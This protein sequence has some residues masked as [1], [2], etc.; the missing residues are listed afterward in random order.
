M[1]W[2]W[3][4]GYLKHL[5]LLSQNGL[6]TNL[7][8]IGGCFTSSSNNLTTTGIYLLGPIKSTNKCV[9][10]Y[11]FQAFKNVIYVKTHPVVY[12][13]ELTMTAAGNTLLGVYEYCNKEVPVLYLVFGQ[14]FIYAINS[15][16]LAKFIAKI[17]EKEGWRSLFRWSLGLLQVGR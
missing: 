10:T 12:T 2:G 9:S 13:C 17:I 11:F 6:I 8:C 5:F 4:S 1:L 3:S 7:P 14:Q 15:N 16:L